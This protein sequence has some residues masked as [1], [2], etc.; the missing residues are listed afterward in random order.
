M[1]NYPSTSMQQKSFMNWKHLVKTDG[2]RSSFLISKQTNER[3]NIPLR[4]YN[5][6]RWWDEYNISFWICMDETFGTRANSFGKCF[7]EIYFCFGNRSKSAIALGCVGEKECF[8]LKIFKCEYIQYLS[9]SPSTQSK[10]VQKKGR[11]YFSI[12]GRS[13]GVVNIYTKLYRRRH[14]T[15]K[16]NQGQFA[17]TAE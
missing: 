10:E 7:I 14:N 12:I 13:T 8:L 17:V 6:R 3:A 4:S 16:H 1:W 15:K 5:K 9:F 11:N 2:K